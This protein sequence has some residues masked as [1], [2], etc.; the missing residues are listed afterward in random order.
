[1]KFF[2]IT[3]LGLFG[4]ANAGTAVPESPVEQIDI[5]VFSKGVIDGWTEKRFSGSTDYQINRYDGRS[6][7]QAS[8]SMSASGLYHKIRVDLDKYP[9]LNWS[10]RI[11]QPLRHNHE[12]K[13]S[14]DDFVARVYVVMDGGLAFWRTRALNYV[15][16]AHTEI[17]ENWPNPFAGKSAMMWTLRSGEDT[18]QQWY[19]ERRNISGDLR[20]VF[21]EDVRYIDAV[22]IMTDTD[23]TSGAAR[24]C[25]GDIY[26]SAE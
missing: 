8:S 16:S 5:G 4:Y 10:W 17:G 21:G 26:F 1:M 11:E 18:A 24:A 2:I 22:A 23:N 15:W 14:G 25:Y 20:A 7:L 12:K 6:C 19:Q 3:L 13:R 9:Y